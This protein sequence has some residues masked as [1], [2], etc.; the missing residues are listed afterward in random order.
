MKRR[1]MTAFRAHDWRLF[2]AAFGFVLAVVGMGFFIGGNAHKLG[3]SSRN[4]TDSKPLTQSTQPTQSARALPGASLP[5]L[6]LTTNG[7]FIVSKN[8]QSRVKLVSGN[9]YGFEQANFAPG[10]LDRQPLS[11]IVAQ[12]KMLGLNSV[13]LPWATDSWNSNPLV[14]S[15]ALAANPGLVGLHE[16]DLMDKVVNELARQGLMVV[17]DNHNS[18]PGWCCS[19][20][21]GNA[22]WWEHYNPAAPPDWAGMGAAQRT[23]LYLQGDAS[24]RQAWQDIVTRYSPGGSDPQPAIVGADL[25]NEPR[26]DSK[27]GLRSIWGGESTP[28][29]ENWQ[30]AATTA[31]DQLLAINPNLLIM[32]EGVNYSVYLGGFDDNTDLPVSPANGYRG[33][34]GYPVQLSVPHQLVYAPHNYSWDRGTSSTKLG[35]WWG[36]VLGNSSYQAPVWVGE[37]GTC[38]TSAVNCLTATTQGAWW[39]TITSYLRKTDVDWSYWAV[40]GMKDAVKTESYGLLNPSWSGEALP[41]LSQDLRDLEAAS[42]IVVGR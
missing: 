37:F 2:A 7:R 20:T 40:N 3:P 16:H 5:S 35:Q 17:L 8:T 19:G 11:A 29:Y 21:D 6:P 34:G 14:P 13:R 42:Q 18:T 31:G 12:I 28:A 10:G 27:L 4:N 41:Q 25:R 26:N 38:N 9:W 1:R 30:H 36:Y 24:W 23:Q 15:S 22:L 32:V 33:A 39:Q